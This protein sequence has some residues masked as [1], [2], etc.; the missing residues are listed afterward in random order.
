MV[1]NSDKPPPEAIFRNGSMR[2]VLVEDHLMFR[3][4]IRKACLEDS[5]HDVV[6]ET[7]SGLTAVHLT[8]QLRPDVVILNLAL[9]DLDGFTVIEQVRRSCPSVRILVL[10]SDLDESIAFRLNLLGVQ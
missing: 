6:G 2:V 7:N 9:P 3:E 10:S 8:L 4:A 1:F 5:G